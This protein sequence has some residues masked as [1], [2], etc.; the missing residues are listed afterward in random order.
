[1]FRTIWYAEEGLVKALFAFSIFVLL[2]LWFISFWRY[3]FS[4]AFI[5][6]HYSVFFGFDR[7]GPRSDIFLFPV[8]GTIIAFTNTAVA[9]FALAEN[10]LWQGATYALT[11][12]FELLLTASLLLVV[13]RTF[14]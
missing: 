1:M 2:F 6:L 13:L 8:L 3:C 11:L 10:R 7:F 14:S 12:F 4:E 5:P 9:R